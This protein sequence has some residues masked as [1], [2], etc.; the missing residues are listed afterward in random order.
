MDC[1]NYPEER[2]LA[3]GDPYQ[4]RIFYKF[5]DQVCTIIDVDF[6]RLEIRIQNKT[7]DM[8]HRAFGTLEN[9]TWDDFEYFLQDRCF[10]PTR[11]N[12]KD[13]LEAL[14]LDSYDP[15][16]IVEKT[17]GRTAEDHMHMEFQ[18]RK[19]ANNAGN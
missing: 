16:Q 8:L 18:Y 17:G 9:P 3:F 14:G 11:G 5:R 1:I 6:L 19:D 13:E 4:M 12:V 7:D 2:E 10:P 15:L